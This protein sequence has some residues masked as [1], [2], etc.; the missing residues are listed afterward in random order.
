M[1]CTL[2]A[3]APKYL[4]AWLAEHDWWEAVGRAGASNTL[5]ISGQVQ[6]RGA[7]GPSPTAA[8]AALSAT[9]VHWCRLAARLWDC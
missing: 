5:L 3:M 6:R 2:A 8:R 9:A 1:S 7:A 4:T